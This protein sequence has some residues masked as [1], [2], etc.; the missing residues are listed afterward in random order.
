MPF[1][2]SLGQDEWCNTHVK[3]IYVNYFTNLRLKELSGYLAGVP[4]HSRLYSTKSF[5]GLSF[6]YISF[7]SHEIKP[8]RK[9]LCP[10][11]SKHP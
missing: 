11:C 9:F 5:E 6:S 2:I 4:V 8:S 3:V 1:R 10:C 7:Q